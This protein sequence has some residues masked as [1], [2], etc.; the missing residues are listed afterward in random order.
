MNR[1]LRIV[2]LFKS[3]GFP[4]LSAFGLLL[5]TL[6]QFQLFSQ[7]LS[8]ETIN[9][10]TSSTEKMIVI[11]YGEKLPEEVLSNIGLE[12]LQIQILDTKRNLIDSFSYAT[13]HNFQFTVPGAFQLVLKSEDASAHKV[14]E[15]VGECNHEEHDKRFQL[16]VLPY[17]MEF[18]L[19]EVTFSTEIV[20]GMEMR[21]Q[22]VTIPV[23]FFSF[24]NESQEFPGLRVLSAGVNTTIQGKTT[25]APFFL[26]PGLNDITFS[27]EGIAS[28]GTYIMFDFIDFINRQFSYAYPNLLK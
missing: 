28:K 10:T 24:K 8:G 11:C 23:Q 19:N 21:G 16:I 3:F 15:K 4:C 22:T 27:L 6:F 7:N 18:N 26:N 1:S 17:R 13:N 5:A 25:D 2:T 12:N 9:N 14:G 20:G